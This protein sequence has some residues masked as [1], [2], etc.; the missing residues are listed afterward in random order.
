MSKERL[1][2]LL[3][4]RGLFN[5]REQARRS[6]LAGEVYV[7]GRRESKAGTSVPCTAEVELRS[8]TP[9]Y[10]SRGGLKLEKALAVFDAKV[11]GRDVLDVGASTGGFTDCLLQHGARHVW[12]VDV[13]YGQLDW[14]LRNDPRVT[15][16]ERTNI[17]YVRPD[18]LPPVQLA[19]I[20]VSFISLRMVLPPV[21]SL[22]APEG[23]IVAL[24]KPQFEAGR[25]A[26][27]KKGVVRRPQVHIEVLE[28][29]VAV[30]SSLGLV[31]CALTHSPITGPRGNIEFLMHLSASHQASLGQDWK[32]E[33]GKAVDL[34]HR[35]L[36]SSQL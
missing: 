26:V 33:I 23:D 20:D 29:V 18:Q 36:A 22:L 12:A 5:T 24:V 7:D 25:E 21:L 1:D 13:G 11:Q 27:G 9:R 10:V 30:A 15:V 35:E 34:A 2:T 19:T 28:N 3:V 17:R 4:R 6:I 8:Q 31:V 16:M 14:H 32:A